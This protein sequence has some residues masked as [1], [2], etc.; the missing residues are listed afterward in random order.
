MLSHVPIPTAE[1]AE[2]CLTVFAGGG[3]GAE[4]VFA[5]EILT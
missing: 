3:N 2:N 4:I 1:E 5:T